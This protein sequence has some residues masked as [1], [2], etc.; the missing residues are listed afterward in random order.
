MLPLSEVFHF[1]D[2]RP[3]RRV[4]VAI[5]REVMGIIKNDDRT[6]QYPGHRQKQYEIRRKSTTSE[7]LQALPLKPAL[8]L[9]HPAAKQIYFP[10]S[11]FL[12]DRAHRRTT[13]NYQFDW[14]AK[15]PPRPC[16]FQKLIGES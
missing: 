9:P 5:A 6:L 3:L 1:L 14:Q 2:L 16:P 12:A 11:N 15:R 10:V 7:L 13:I 4:E 8:Q